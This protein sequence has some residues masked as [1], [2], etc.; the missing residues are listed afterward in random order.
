MGYRDLFVDA[1]VIAEGSVDKAFEGGHYYRGMRL[2]KEALDALIQYRIGQITD[3]YN[4]VDEGL[5]KFIV[6][7]RRNPTPES[8]TTVTTSDSFLKLFDE[9]FLVSG[10]QCEMTICFVRD[11]SNLLALVS[12]VREGDIERHMQAER[13]MLKLLFAFNHQNYSRYLSYQHVLLS[14]MKENNTIAFHDFRARGFGASYSSNKFSAVHGD[15]VTEYFNRETKGTSGPFRHGFSTSITTMNN[16]VKN[17][18]IH[19]M[20]RMTMRDKL[21]VKVSSTHKEVTD[22]AKIRHN[23]HVVAIKTQ[24]AQYNTDPFSS[25]PAKN[26]V[27]GAEIDKSVI[28]NLVHASE[29]GNDAYKTFT[30]ERL[31]DPTVSFFS[32]IKRTKITTGL[33]P[34]KTKPKAQAVLLEDTQAFGV[35]CAKAITLDEALKY[36][37]TSLPLSLALPDGTMR[38]GAKSVFR[39]HLLNSKKVSAKLHSVPKNVRWIYDGMRLFIKTTKNLQRVFQKYFESC[40]TSFWLTAT[41]N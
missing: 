28:K 15:L 21:N 7:L 10:P 6:A 1:G 24:L 38:Q 3:S 8:I 36:P 40:N 18:H 13:Q 17:I 23:N 37:M 32:P 12:S 9:I 33:K 14:D 39:E 19:A 22:S 16:W 11:V 27:T 29:I 34:P 25:G 5:L 30:K 35:L 4:K 41:S 2:L 26:I 20:L 31:T